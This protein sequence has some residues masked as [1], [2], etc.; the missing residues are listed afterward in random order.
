MHHWKSFLIVLCLFASGTVSAR[1]RC[2]GAL[3]PN[4]PDSCYPCL[5]C[6]PCCTGCSDFCQD[7]K[8]IVAQGTYEDDH[9]TDIRLLG[10]DTEWEL[11]TTSLQGQYRPRGFTFADSWLDPSLRIGYGKGNGRLMIGGEPRFDADVTLFR[12]GAGLHWT[13]WNR[14]GA[15]LDLDY[16]KLLDSGTTTPVTAGGPT[17]NSVDFSALAAT[18]SVRY[19]IIPGRLTGSAGIRATRGDVVLEQELPA[20]GRIS[21]DSADLDRQQVVAAAEVRFTRSLS[22]KVE[23][24]ISDD[25]STSVSLRY[26]IGRGGRVAARAAGIS[27]RD[28]TCVWRGGRFCSEAGFRCLV[29]FPESE[30]RVA[31]PRFADAAFVTGTGEITGGAQPVLRYEFTSAPSMPVPTFTIDEP[32]PL[33]AS[34]SQVLGFESVTILPG[35]YSVDPRLGSRGGIV[36]NVRVSTASTANPQDA[37]GQ[38][39]DEGIRH[40]RTEL[41]RHPAAAHLSPAEFAAAFHTIMEPWART[42]S[43]DSRYL[44][45]SGV[46][47]PEQAYTDLKSILDR[48]RDDPAVRER[49]GGVPP[50]PSDAHRRIVT[51]LRRLDGGCS[52]LAQYRQELRAIEADVVGGTD[53]AGL[54]LTSLARHGAVLYEPDA[55]AASKTFPWRDVLGGDLNGASTGSWLGGFTGPGGAAAGGVIGGIFGSALAL[56][57]H[58]YIRD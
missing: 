20:L 24:T 37:F 14:W 11:A 49:L 28:L 27:S 52:D 12:G 46:A 3:Y 57:D 30:W 56:Y 58:G 39:H 41:A 13:H 2:P 17:V 50:V 6:T 5:G 9:F 43:R 48:I 42:A 25:R 22:A 15:D 16:R 21:R 19:G 7:P 40:F 34:A 10:G 18:L 51:A 29:L 44:S 35:T 26:G 32:V 1:G 45:M 38:L 47:T 23:T 33:S 55:A 31:G 53:P 36:Y 54:R 8:N 4:P